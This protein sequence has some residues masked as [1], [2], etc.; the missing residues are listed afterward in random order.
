[1][2]YPLTT[3]GTGPGFGATYKGTTTKVVD[4][5]ADGSDPAKGVVRQTIRVQPPSEQ[6]RIVEKDHRIAYCEISPDTTGMAGLSTVQ[7]DRSRE[8]VKLQIFGDNPAGNRVA[9][10]YLPYQQDSNHRITLHDR[11]GL[12]NPDFFITDIVNGCSVYVEGTATKPT[13]YHLNAISTLPKKKASDLTPISLMP[14]YA[15]NRKL[16]ERGWQLKWETMDARV[17]TDAPPPSS[18]AGLAS[19]NTFKVEA[20]DYQ[21]WPGPPTS[22]FLASLS[23]LQAQCRIPRLIGTDT[24]D[25]LD[26]QTSEGTVFGVRE[27]TTWRFFVQK[28]VLVSLIHHAA[29]AKLTRTDRMAKFFTG[30]SPV[31]KRVIGTQWAIRTVDEFFPRQASGRMIAL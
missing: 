8:P 5:P 1:Q 7:A 18:T 12:V 11:S 16:F 25:E 23:Q 19:R 13:V 6:A 27:G 10:F 4:V 28:K 30:K 31:V 2:K 20:P 14:K 9:C 26:L 17:R 3:I 22:A 24:V 21:V 15:D 29:P